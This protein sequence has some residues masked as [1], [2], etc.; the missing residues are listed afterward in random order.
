MMNTLSLICIANLAL[1]VPVLYWEEH[2]RNR[3]CRPRGRQ[4]LELV[5]LA[6]IELAT[7]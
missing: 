4:A 7:Y 6:G 3:A 1:F 5:L 2:Q